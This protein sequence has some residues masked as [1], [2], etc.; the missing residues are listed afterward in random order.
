MDLHFNSI[1]SM[2]QLLSITFFLNINQK[3][4]TYVYQM[5]IKNWNFEEWY[6]AEP[7]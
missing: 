7:V 1:V 6:A 4:T 5:L 3:A 2:T